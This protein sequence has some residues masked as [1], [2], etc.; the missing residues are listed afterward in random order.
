M[1]HQLLLES[2]EPALH[3]IE[4]Q[5]IAN[6]LHA[7]LLQVVDK[8]PPTT[9]KVFRMSRIEQKST[10]EIARELSLSEQTVKNNISMA[11]LSLKKHLL[12]AARFFLI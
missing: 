12:T 1:R 3:A 6:E 10:R 4:S 8:L 11:L 9:R 2:D 7:E 5:V